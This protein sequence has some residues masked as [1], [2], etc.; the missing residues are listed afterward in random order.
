MYRGYVRLWRKTSESR[1]ASRGLVYFGAMSWFLTKTIHQSAWIA[2]QQINRG[3]VAVTRS[4]LC[5]EWKVSEQTV[6][7]ILKN[8][9]SDG[10]LTIKPTNRLTIVTICNYDT[11]QQCQP[12]E[13]PTNQPAINQQSTNSLNIYNNIYNNNKKNVKNVNNDVVEDN[14]ATKAKEKKKRTTASKPSSAQ[15]VIDYCKERNNGIDGQYFWDKM[16]AR[17]WCFKDGRPVKDWKACVRTWEKYNN[18]QQN[19]TTNTNGYYKFDGN[20]VPDRNPE[21]EREDIR[22]F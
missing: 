3:Q 11:Y 5:Y 4:Q 19:N 15:E 2:G 9:E 10:F 17:G 12:A 14:T 20:T 21:L 1:S 8:L 6:R 13:Q 18:T 16:E 22:D 7:T